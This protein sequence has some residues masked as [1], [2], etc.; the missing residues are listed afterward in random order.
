ME[1]YNRNNVNRIKKLIIVSIFILFLIPTILCI[2]LMLKLNS[3]EERLDEALTGQNKATSSDGSEMY[4]ADIYSESAVA[5]MKDVESYDDIEKGDYENDSLS[6]NDLADGTENDV[7][8]NGKKVYLTF[9]DGPGE[10][11]NE[12]L[13]ILKEK[14]VKATFF[15]I[16]R[17][18]EYYDEYRRIVAEGH[19]L[20]MHSYSHVYSEIYADID[21]FKEDVTKIHD[22]IY[23]VT[24]V[25]TRLYRFPGGSSNSVSKVSISECISYLDEQG[26]TYFD[27]NALNGDAVTENLTKDELIENV[28]KYVRKNE[29]DSVILMHDLKT[30]HNTVESLAELIDILQA[31]GYE[32][33]PIDDTTVPCQHVKA[34]ALSVMDEEKE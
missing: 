26:I 33:V 11:T 4:N 28:M 20:G 18:E 29:G 21:S 14:N 31:E 24:G 23:E 34:P 27:W 25:D 10:N 22:L 15:V 2:C 6:S 1:E 5:E 30:R 32:I 12:I 16:G 3:L 19:T 17:D 7:K 8:S 9:D 13:D